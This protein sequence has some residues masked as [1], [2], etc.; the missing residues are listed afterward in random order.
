MWK[1]GKFVRWIVYVSNVFLML[2]G[3]VA[4]SLGIWVS[5]EIRDTSNDYDGISSGSKLSIILYSV[6]TIVT[7]TTILGLYSIMKR[8]HNLTIIFIL[9]LIALIIFEIILVV[10]GFIQ[11]TDI[12]EDIQRGWNSLSC[13]QQQSV[14]YQLSCCG[15]YNFTDTHCTCFFS[16]PENY[17]GC[18][19]QLLYQLDKYMSVIL[20]FAIGIL[21]T[22]VMVLVLTFCLFFLRDE[23]DYQYTYLEEAV[24]L[25]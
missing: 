14:E 2:V 11:N 16:T 1:C 5:F 7:F 8:K 25:A 13:E 3:L 20:G 19:P 10:F 21:G 17:I 24:P 23:W 6:A 18:Y 4:F 12:P 15:Y 22:E 9:S